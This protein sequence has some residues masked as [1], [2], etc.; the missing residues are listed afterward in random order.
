MARAL[1]KNHVAA[2]PYLLPYLRAAEK[3]GAAFPSLLWASPETQAARFDAI[4]RLGNLHGKSVLDVG[5]G[6]ADMLEYLLLR[7]VR[8]ADYIGIEAVEDLAAAA[9]ANCRRLPDA[10]ILR[11]DFVRD[12][13]KMFVAADVVLFSGSLNTLDETELD[14]TIRRAF[15]AAAETLIFN[16]LCHSHLAG[17]S[18]LRWRRSEAV[19]A[20]AKTLT[21]H[22]R[23][24]D[25][26]L[27]GD[28]T[29]ALHKNDL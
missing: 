12:P 18:Y 14:R 23:T 21:P 9:E 10:A 13:A 20:F 5:C 17:A 11:A 16:F 27:P 28:F 15:D 1:S 24:L 29:I 26:Y 2:E 19:I 4:E 3:H 6:R 25:D 22:I 8:P 7:G